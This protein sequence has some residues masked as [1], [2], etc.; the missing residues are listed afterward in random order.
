MINGV[1]K[2]FLKLLARISG[3]GGGKKEQKNRTT[4]L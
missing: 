3:G 4:K 1:P 2:F